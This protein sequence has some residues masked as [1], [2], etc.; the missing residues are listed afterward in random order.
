[1]LTGFGSPGYFLLAVAEEEELES[2][3]NIVSDIAAFWLV[4]VKSGDGG[5]HEMIIV[6]SHLGV[7]VRCSGV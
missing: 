6:G 7:D 5:A 2:W 1:M 4:D 3:R